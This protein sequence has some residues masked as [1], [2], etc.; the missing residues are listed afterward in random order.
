VEEAQYWLEQI[1]EY[2]RERNIVQVN[3]PIPEEFHVTAARGEGTY[4]GRV[5]NLLRMGSM[6]YCN[7]IEAFVD[8]DLRLQ[9]ER[10]RRGE[11]GPSTS[12]LFNGAIGDWHMSVLGAALWGK[13]LSARVALLLERARKQ[14]KPLGGASRSPVPGHTPPA[15]LRPGLGTGRK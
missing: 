2:C 8:E 3:T 9:V 5:C 11:E 10:D 4:P 1:T 14:A 6:N 12:P 15:R 13:V 7:P